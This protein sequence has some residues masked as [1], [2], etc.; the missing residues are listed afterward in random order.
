MR[1]GGVVD[2]HGV[3]LIDVLFISSSLAGVVLKPTLVVCPAW[4]FVPF[5]TM[6][7][8]FDSHLSADVCMYVQAVCVQ[9]E[10]RQI[11]SFEYCCMYH[12]ITIAHRPL[13]TFHRVSSHQSFT[14]VYTSCV[15]IVCL[16]YLCSA[17]VMYRRLAVH[18]KYPC[19]MS[20]E[21]NFFLSHYPLKTMLLS[22]LFFSRL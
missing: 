18:T 9:N 15:T 5:F 17:C 22:F 19:V 12:A 16:Q 6:T 7:C 21:C 13:L 1:G 11:L 14:K 3:N 8:Y 20:S 10:L 4:G 2:V